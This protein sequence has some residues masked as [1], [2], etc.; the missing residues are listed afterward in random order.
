M[1]ERSVGRKK[2]KSRREEE[3]FFI[4][5]SLYPDPFTKA[6]R[7]EKRFRYVKGLL[8]SS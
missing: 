5:F 3:E 7:E 8:S 6:G 1:G 2:R 4:L